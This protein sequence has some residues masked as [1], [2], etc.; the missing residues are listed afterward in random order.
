MADRKSIAE[1]LWARVVRGAVNECW[2]WT[3]SRN[4]FGYGRI[5]RD[6]DT[7]VPAH[8]VAWEVSVGQIPDGLSVLHRC[9]NPPCCNPSHLFVGT[10]KEN[11]QDMVA[12]GRRR[13]PA[14]D[15]RWSKVRP[16]VVVEIRRQLAAGRLQAEI[17][18]ELGITPSAVSLI[19]TGANWARLGGPE[20]RHHA[21]FRG[22]R[23][24]NARLTEADVREIRLRRETIDAQA[25]RFRVSRSTIKAVRAG[26]IWQHVI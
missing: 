12:K 5:R 23:S 21:D 9:D 3:G 11:A 6:R 10:Q 15:Q 1:R 14:P 25:A 4:D 16:D 2:P 24:P 26:T 19:N 22:E 18:A 7:L 8:R 13:G 20:G 17:A